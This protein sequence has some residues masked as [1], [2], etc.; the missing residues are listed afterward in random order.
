M[1]KL[2]EEKG[3]K[4]ER[5]YCSV[6]HTQS[7]IAYCIPCRCYICE[8]CQ[9]EVHFEHDL[10]H[11]E[12]ECLKIFSEYKK[13]QY[14][15]QE[16]AKQYKLQSIDKVVSN[17]KAQIS[18]KFDEL[19]TQLIGLKEQRIKELLN[20][21]ELKSTINDSIGHD[22]HSLVVLRKIQIDAEKLMEQIKSDFDNRRYITLFERNVSAEL[23]QIRKRIQEWK[24]MISHSKI[25]ELGTDISVNMNRL[26]HK[27]SSLIGISFVSRPSPQ[28]IYSFDNENNKL[29][30]YDMQ[31]RTTQIICFGSHFHI[32]FHYS[33]AI[34]D[35]KIFFAGGDDDGYRKDCYALSFTKKYVQKLVDLNTER[36][37][38][39]LVAL[40]IVRTMYCVGGYNK[41]QGALSSVEKYDFAN[42]RWICIA[43]LIEKR[44]WPGVCQFNNKLIFCFGGSNLSSIERLDIINEDR[45]WELVTIKHNS[46]GWFGRSACVAIQLNPSQIL[47]FG[48][49]AKRDLDEAVLYT[50]NTET[51]A[52]S[53]C[54][55]S[56]S[57]F[58]QLSPAISSKYVGIIGWRNEN[59]YMYS[60]KSNRWVCIEPAVYCPP[61]FEHN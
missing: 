5:N 38:H 7:M 28:F 41:K 4:K 17:L 27:L 32:P 51:I 21:E 24:E 43:S 61:D 14:E 46:G 11:L 18:T 30:L 22:E 45:G 12:A 34:L 42:P 54:L 2:E 35:T 23:G 60:T 19:I 40:H 52:N 1:D 59:V 53:A 8:N 15:T 29:L 57:L 31:K 37:N 44:Q 20:S 50:P 3:A 25:G 6:E 39:T 36:R 10:Q 49:C 47:I 56:P 13:V 9:A 55:P 16:I 48:G 33:S 26:E 58:C